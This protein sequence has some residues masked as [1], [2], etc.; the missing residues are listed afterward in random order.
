M[1]D[2]PTTPES[3]PNKA[4]D[5]ARK[6]DRMRFKSPEEFSDPTAR[7]TA[8]RDNPNN[9]GIAPISKESF[10][11]MRAANHEFDVRENNEGPVAAQ[12][13]YQAYSD[14][15]QPTRK[16]NIKKPK[17]DQDWNTIFHVLDDRER[18]IIKS[19]SGLV[20]G[21]DATLAEMSLKHGIN[22]ATI[23]KIESGAMKKLQLHAQKYPNCDDPDNC[24]GI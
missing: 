10:N 13:N 6:V 5:P 12:S 24:P 7:L 18:D 21:Q 3:K 4:S 19:R 11:L 2:A 8:M 9:A 22:E 17:S 14:V 20:R 1:S 15:V 16:P 23:R